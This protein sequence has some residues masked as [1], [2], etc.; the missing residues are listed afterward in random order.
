MEINGFWTRTIYA[1]CNF[2][3]HHKI[4]MAKK[5]IPDVWISIVKIEEEMVEFEVNFHDLFQRKANDGK[6]Y[7]ILERLVG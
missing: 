2:N 5:T 7:S 3:V 4:S 6:K 1:I